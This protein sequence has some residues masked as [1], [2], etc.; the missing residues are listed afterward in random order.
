[1]AFCRKT[2][3]FPGKDCRKT[4]S[5]GVLPCWL[6]PRCCCKDY[7]RVEEKALRSVTDILLAGL[8]ENGV[9]VE[10]T[11]LITSGKQVIFEIFDSYQPGDLLVMLIGHTEKKLVLGYIR[12]YAE[13]VRMDNSDEI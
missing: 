1:M 5:L 4:E 6:R 3:L 2:R 11:A 13:N 7:V 9:R 12:E 10:N 8:L